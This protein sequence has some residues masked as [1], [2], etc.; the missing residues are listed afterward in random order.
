MQPFTEF[1]HT[2]PYA[3]WPWELTERVPLGSQCW[4]GEALRAQLHA[5]VAFEKARREMP[6]YYYRIGHTIAFPL[7]VAQRPD[8]MPPGIPDRFTYPW[9]IW[10]WWALEERWR[11][12]HAAWRQLDDSEAGALLQQEI[13]A[14]DGWS[15]FLGWGDRVQLP[16]GH[17]AGCLSLFLSDADDWD[18][19]LRERALKTAQ[20]HLEEVVRP[21]FADVWAERPIESP[22]QL[23]NIPTIVLVR[24]AQLAR[25]IGHDLA[26]PLER[27]ARTALAA[28]C[29]YRTS[30]DP[31]TE[32]T[33]YDGYLMD[34]IT[35]WIGTLPD[36]D[37]LVQEHGAA[38]DSLIHAWVHLALPARP[39]LH[40]P[41]G[42]VE[43]EMPFWMS[44]LLRL[45]RWRGSTEGAWLLKRLPPV[46]LPA[47]ALALACAEN[48]ETPSAEPATVTTVP[49]A[50]TM[51]TGWRGDDLLVAV[52]GS[53]SA[54][55]HLHNDGGQLILGWRN[56]CWIT[57]PGYQQYRRGPEREYTIGVQAHSGPVID[58]AAQAQR[59]VKVLALAEAPNGG[60]HAA[61]DL[62]GCYAELPSGDDNAAEASVRRDVWLV[63][64][65]VTDAGPKSTLVVACDRIVGL[66]VGTS[67]DTHWQGSAHLAW[68][69]V[70]G[71]ARLSDGERTLWLGGFPHPVAAEMLVRHEG[72]RGPLTLA[73]HAEAP[74]GVHHQWWVFCCVD[75]VTWSP[76][77][78]S[79]DGDGLVVHGDTGS[80][81]RISWAD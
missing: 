66:P 30:A 77:A 65:R 12:L 9:I 58:G 32:G 26:E 25:A 80:S 22:N 60:H 68:A 20:R 53:R 71:W 44:A 36:R 43:P 15:S 4:D 41:L 11:V 33:S 76:P 69:F 31:H 3:T 7:P 70:D 38:F 42:D 18:P 27:T 50:V 63:P 21:W 62:T 52:G 2:F 73:H 79:L 72:S 55:S 14:L 35:E 57:D 47:A 45:S 5:R 59:A 6:V 54:M 1:Q 23:H 16:T 39:D 74:V 17:S 28:W 40:V 67:I 37:A 81:A 48:G 61:L 75:A 8:V 56:R 51:R 64:E 49:N 13:A 19:T 10:L 24:N 34:T 46:R 29:A 78:V